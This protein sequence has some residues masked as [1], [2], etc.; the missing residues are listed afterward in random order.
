MSVA[1]E[2]TRAVG[3]FDR[4]L[5]RVVGPP[6]AVAVATLAAWQ[7]FV[8]ATGVPPVVLPSPVDVVVAAAASLPTL[9]AAAAVTAATA[10]LGLGLGVVT[11]LALAF[12]MT[13]STVGTAVVRPYV[14]SLRV[15]PLV[16]IAP[17]V[18]LW[19]GDGLVARA[20]LVAT[21]TV[22]PV[23]VASYDG[24][25]SVPSPLL[26]LAES[27]GAGPLTAFVRVRVPAAAPSVF[28]GVKLA[29]A[30]SV[31]G[32]VVAE[33]VALRAGLGYRIV[34]T[35]QYLQTPRTFAA[36]GVLAVLG[37]SFYLVPAV[38]ERWITRTWT[39]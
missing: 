13:A 33:F 3:R 19:A 11:G 21:M 9:V 38:A 18:F 37:V 36:L 29:S 24:L 27:V 28:A 7:A 34:Y 20:L 23:T 25:R 22:F 26:D 31:V 15:A 6:A 8:V 39:A 2:R 16:A 30:L 4:R 14:V 10:L 1:T 12:V 17:L 35:S 5:V 32:A